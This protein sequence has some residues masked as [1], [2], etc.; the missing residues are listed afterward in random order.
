MRTDLNY[1][2]TM[3]NGD[4]ALIREMIEIFNKQVY[5]LSKEMQD[6]LEK[7]DYESL[8]KVAHKA[9]TSVAIMGMNDLS[10]ELKELELNAKDQK[11]TDSY[12]ESVENFR[13]ETE[14]AVKELN[15]FIQNL[16]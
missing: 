10:R 1:L 15:D 7:K 8:G 13:I 9:K 16:S 14:E 2:K 12:Q 3:S 4:P 6:L 11:N 5:E